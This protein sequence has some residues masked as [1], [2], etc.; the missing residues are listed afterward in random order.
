M[1]AVSKKDSS[2]EARLAT[3]NGGIT[4]I[5]RPKEV[6][7]GVGKALLQIIQRSPHKVTLLNDLYNHYGMV[8]QSDR[9]PKKLGE[10]VE[11]YGCNPYILHVILHGCCERISAI[12]HANEWDPMHRIDLYEQLEKV[13]GLVNSQLLDM[14]YPHRMYVTVYYFEIHAC[15]RN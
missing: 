15:T 5:T 4:A 9:T 13:C 1:Y 14:P 2:F 8:K 7:A 10:V 12:A 11:Y 3:Y 6:E